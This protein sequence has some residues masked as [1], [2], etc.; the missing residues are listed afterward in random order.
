M[1]RRN[2]ANYDTFNTV[3]LNKLDIQTDGNGLSIYAFN[4]TVPSFVFNPVTNQAIINGDLLVSGSGEFNSIAI[5]EYLGGIFNVATDNAADAIDIG[6]AGKY[7][8]GGDRYTGFVR[9]TSDTLKR[10]TFFK[11]ILTQPVT[12]VVGLDSTK[13]A[14]ILAESI[15]LN[16]GSASAPSIAFD[17]D[18]SKNTGFYRAGEDSIGITAGG[19][20]V[21]TISRTSGSLSNFTLNTDT[22]LSALKINTVDDSILSAGI[23]TGHLYIESSSATDKWFK[24]HSAST[25]GTPAYTG[26]VFSSPTDYFFVSNVGSTFKIFGRT[27]SDA[28]NV[29]P[30]Y[31]VAN[32][33]IL[34]LT[35][36]I[37]ETKLPL[38]IP[39]GSLG[40]LA[41]RF[42]SEATTGIYRSGSNAI[43]IVGNG[44]NLL[45]I[46]DSNIT[47]SRA[48]YNIDGTVSLPSITFTNNTDMGLYRAASNTLGVSVA[49]VNKLTLTTSALNIT[50]GN[51]VNVGTSGTTSPLNVYGLTTIYGGITSVNGQS[52]NVGTSGSTSP[53]NVYGAATVVGQ[54]ILNG[55][56][57]SAIASSSVYIA[58][59]STTSTASDYYFTSYAIP[60]LTSVGVVTVPNAYTVY[61]A[62]APA[63]AGST[64]ITNPYALVVA[65]GKSYFG[66]QLLASDGTVSAPSIAFV[67]DSG[68]DTGFYRIGEGNIGLTINGTKQIDIAST[69]TSWTT[70]HTVNIGTSGTT[71]ILNVYGTANI[72]KNLAITATLGGSDTVATAPLYI[73]P[74]STAVTG[75]NNYYFSYFATPATTGSTTGAATTVYIDGAPTGTV[76][77]PYALFVSSGATRLDNMTAT[78]INAS[79]LITA[80]LGLTIS[81]N[82]VSILGAGS[83]TVSSGS[84]YIAPQSTTVTSSVN[85]YTTYMER[86]TLTSGSAFTV[87]IAA[88][89]Y[90]KNSPLAAGSTTITDTY[91]IYVESGNSYFGGSVVMNS[92]FSIAN[93]QTMNIGTSGTTATLN[94]FGVF[95][96]NSISTFTGVG[97]ATNTTSTVVINPTSTTVSG[98]NNYYFTS[99]KQPT[100]SGSTTGAAYTLFIE[101]A[102]VG[103][104]TNPYSLY[105]AAGISLVQALT[106]IG[107]I[108][109]NAGITVVTG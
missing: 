63:Q 20:V 59:A 41:L 107:L 43:G 104:I 92:G 105:V 11:E 109:A 78:T 40:S 12:T 24:L 30:D 27:H 22:I 50:T 3:Y 103:T 80:S 51:T 34:A 14:G 28:V 83:S 6:L 42:N 88:T 33:E 101:G 72:T 1:S 36:T 87:P 58:P 94:V 23:T 29:A 100:T 8:N 64:T 37:A 26:A 106:A 13:W 45:N 44:V 99:L 16:D 68:L 35:T 39:F 62:G 69:T 85:Y 71:S 5:T 84:L 31:R 86:P 4:S 65:S 76:S 25:A 55:V 9:D 75:S 74:G 2:L 91:S 54:T 98:S 79:G 96:V 95:N 32:T 48:F 18:L 60:T 21:A 19:E 15:H 47:A 61:I 77:S 108:T 70:G 89:L 102:P 46:S 66:D 82:T 7:V 49:G 38:I 73:V 90:V 53:L 97:S 67:S 57:G 10:F 17:I 81:N 52:V 56:G 93:G